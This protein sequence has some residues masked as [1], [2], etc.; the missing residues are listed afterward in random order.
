M[1][2]SESDFNFIY[3]IFKSREKQLLSFTQLEGLLALGSYDEV[4]AQLPDSP[5]S[6]KARQYGQ[7]EAGIEA[8]VGEEIGEIKAILA[9]YVS[10]SSLKSLIFLPWDFFNLKVSVLASINNEP[11]EELYGP[12]GEV[13][14]DDLAL[15]QETMAYDFLPQ[16]IYDALQNAWIAY[17]EEDK[18]CQAFEIAIDRQKNVV[19]LRHAVSCSQEIYKFLRVNTEIKLAE[20]FL[21][22]KKA[23]FPW[24]L[25][26]WGLE[27][28]SGI[29]RLREMY[30]LPIRD[31]QERLT[32]F[33]IGPFRNLVQ[34]FQ[35]NSD[36]QSLVGEERVENLKRFDSWKYYPP[37]IE[38]C[39]YFLTRKL[40][41]VYTLRLLLL[42]R[43]N[44]LSPEEIRKR[45]GY[46]YL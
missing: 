46:V 34:R 7:D 12:E 41:Q 40:S 25:V 5:F 30:S 43:L 3:G 22:A 19:L 38:Y 36:I 10:Q 17:Y 45:I 9:Q 8:G 28:M 13:R 6:H 23:D 42:G 44:K 27:G 16:D 20:L 1:K 2:K 18:N 29:E 11:H 32:P 15:Q 21:R 33:P 35:E 24:E 31:W 4:I 14:L 37:S 39:Y 26:R